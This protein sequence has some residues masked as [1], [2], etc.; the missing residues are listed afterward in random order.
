MLSEPDPSLAAAPVAGPCAG[1]PL[2]GHFHFR[3][4]RTHTV[5]VMPTSSTVPTA[6]P[7]MMA[8]K[9]AKDVARAHEGSDDSCANER[10]AALLIVADAPNFGE[11]RIDLA[12]VGVCVVL[13]VLPGALLELEQQLVG[14]LAALDHRVLEQMRGAQ[15]S[16]H[17]LVG[18]DRIEDLLRAFGL[19]LGA[20]R[21]K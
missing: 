13:D 4:L 14:H 12:P 3:T 8:A 10:E 18:R 11:L 15:A 20:Q 7:A 16:E 19:Q 6:T 17:R 9:P 2:S 21:Q 5:T 1:T